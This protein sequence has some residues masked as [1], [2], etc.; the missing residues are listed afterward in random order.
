MGRYSYLTADP[1]HV[2]TTHPTDP[3][4]ALR[5]AAD[6]LGPELART[7]VRASSTTSSAVNSNGSPPRGR[8][9]WDCR[10]RGW[11]RMSG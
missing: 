3:G 5:E 2:W 1:T 4:D 9:T 6:Y 8:M 11:P 10:T 7:S